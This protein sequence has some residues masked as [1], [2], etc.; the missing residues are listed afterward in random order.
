MLWLGLYKVIHV[1]TISKLLVT[2][3][4][5]ITIVLLEG[6]AGRDAGRSA[7]IYQAKKAYYPAG[8]A[9]QQ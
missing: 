5:D 1:A 7:Q 2:S 4:Y 3:I 6:M 9:Y 8:A